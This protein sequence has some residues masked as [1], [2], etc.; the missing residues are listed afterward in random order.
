MQAWRTAAGTSCPFT[1]P[2]RRS[3]SQRAASVNYSFSF[4]KP[5]VSNCCVV[6]VLFNYAGGGVSQERGLCGGEAGDMSDERSRGVRS[7]ST[8]QSVRRG[9]APLPLL[10]PLPSP[11]SSSSLLAP[12]PFKVDAGNFFMFAFPFFGFKSFWI[13]NFDFE[14]FQTTFLILDFRSFGSNDYFHLQK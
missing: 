13:F 7:A 10:F 14:P 11:P 1:H 5:L 3:V 6:G 4:S 9:E 2:L 8:G 12:T